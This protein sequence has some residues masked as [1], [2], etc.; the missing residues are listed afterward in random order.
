M[1]CGFMI[2]FISTPNVSVGRSRSGFYFRP[3]IFVPPFSSDFFSLVFFLIL[4]YFLFLVSK[5]PLDSG[6][7]K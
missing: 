6:K 7:K 3:T 2:K 5:H 4:I 1:N